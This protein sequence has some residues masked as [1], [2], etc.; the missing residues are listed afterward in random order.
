MAEVSPFQAVSLMIK[1][2][3]RMVNGFISFRCTDCC[4]SLP[5]AHRNRETIVFS[6][7]E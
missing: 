1:N 7:I 4:V 2:I 6:L 5:N 3:G